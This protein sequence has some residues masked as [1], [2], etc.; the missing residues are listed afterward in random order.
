MSLDGIGGVSVLIEEGKY[1]W[2][3]TMT[4]LQGAASS[5]KTGTPLKTLFMLTSCSGFFFFSHQ[6]RDIS[7]GMQC[8]MRCLMRTAFTGVLMTF[9][10]GWMP[11][12]SNSSTH[13]NLFRSSS[14]CLQLVK[15][16]SRRP[17]VSFSL[18][19]SLTLVPCDTFYRK[20]NRSFLESDET[21]FQ[22]QIE[23]A[24]RLRIARRG[25]RAGRFKHYWTNQLW[26]RVLKKKDCALLR[27]INSHQQRAATLN[28]KQNNSCFC[29]IFS[30]FPRRQ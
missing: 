19:A 6:N 22:G 3:Q 27:K 14:L 16:P 24:V 1:S 4:F 13:A 2:P 15:T 18:A 10:W 11:S 23:S 7:W 21:F 29:V 20:Q 9:I 25:S 28:T 5:C 12:S 30:P 17:P 26:S 8:K